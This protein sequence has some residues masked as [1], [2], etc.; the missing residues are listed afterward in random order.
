MRP[1]AQ[2]VL[3]APPEAGGG[4]GLSPKPSEGARPPPPDTQRSDSGF[5]TWGACGC[6][7]RPRGG[8]RDSGTA[9]ETNTPLPDARQSP[10]EAPAHSFIRS[11]SNHQG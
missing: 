10:P 1:H 7:V 11:P 6:C 5:Q 2:R 3:E 8:P 4:G 9:R